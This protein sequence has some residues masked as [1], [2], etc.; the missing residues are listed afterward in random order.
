MKILWFTNT[1]SLAEEK[2][3]NKPVGGGWIK[4]LE[5]EL[6]NQFDVKL[7]IGFHHSIR[8]DFFEF[9][10]TK[11]YPIY[12]KSGSKLRNLYSRFKGDLLPSDEVDEFIDIIKDFKPDIIHIHGTEE[13]FGLIQKYIKNIPIVISIQGNITVYHYKWYSGISKQNVKKYTNLFTK[14]LFNSYN[15]QIKSFYKRAKRENEIL[16]FTKYIIGRTDWDKRITSVMAP[17]S[18]YFHNDEILRESFY[19]FKWKNNLNETIN[20]FTTSGNNIY[21]GIEVVLY[22]AYLLDEIEFK[23]KW[24]IAGL[25]SNDEIIKIALRALKLRLSPNIIFEGKLS[26][27]IIVKKLL[28]SHIYVMPSHIENSPNNLCE[29]M[30]L[31]LPCIATDVGGTSGL[32][33]TRKEGILIQDGDPWSMAGTIVEMKNNYKQAIEYGKNARKR[34]LE[35]HN[36]GKIVNDLIN[37]YKEII[38]ENTK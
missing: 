25:N 2:L 20:I 27:T 32:L 28:I 29:A 35:R 24:H 23:F 3:T 30:I 14:I 7:G 36:P 19:K 10:K 18:R 31:G 12:F 9:N 26:E 17:N 16:H 13:S 37:I 6:K 11:Y 8:T 5:K 15:S 1:P 21:K 38:E 22:T 33:A 34:A 4:S